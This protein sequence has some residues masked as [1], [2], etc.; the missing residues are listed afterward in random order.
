MKKW[1]FHLAAIITFIVVFCFIQPVNAQNNEFNCRVSI[2]SDKIQA[3]NK[4]IF[5]DME[6]AILEYMNTRPWSNYK[7]SIA[8][9]IECSLFFTINE[10]PQENRFNTELQIQAVRPVYN[11]LYTTTTL[12]FRDTSVEF[13]FDQNETLQYNE[14]AN[15]ITSNLIAVLDFYGNI[16][17]GLDFDSFALHSGSP[18]FERAMNIVNQAQAFAE[19]GWKAFDKNNNR[20]AV[21]S[22]FVD[23]GLKPFRKMWYSYHRLGLDDMT[24]NVDRGRGKITA[25]LPDLKTAYDTRPGNVI[26]TLFSDAKMDEILNIYSKAQQAEKEEVHKL[27]VSIYPAMTNRLDALKR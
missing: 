16:I 11:A 12:N 15:S 13:T 24:G 2:N 17:L 22:A 23:E 27:L 5:I 8:E 25:A 18:F 9:R 3:S 19:T 26:F 7:I 6:K 14:N 20:H 10:M 1:T 21:A 4:Q